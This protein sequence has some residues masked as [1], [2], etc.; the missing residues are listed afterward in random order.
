MHSSDKPHRSHSVAA[1]PERCVRDDT[2]HASRR[3]TEPILGDKEL[4][5][6]FH[7][8]KNRRFCKGSGEKKLHL[9][10]RS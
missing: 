1:R 10:F 7:F 5:K 2:A 6:E 8:S 9:F 3:S 4:Y